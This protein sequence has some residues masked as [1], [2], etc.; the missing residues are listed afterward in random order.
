MDNKCLQCNKSFVPKRDTKGI[1]C[2]LPCYHKHMVGKSHGHKT[3][4]GR[5]PWNKGLKIPEMCGDNH[6]AWKGEKVSY[7]NL[8]K[9]VERILGKPHN[10]EECKNSSLRHRQYNW[11]NISGNYKRIIS[12]W[13]R[14]CMK[15][16]KAFDMNRAGSL[17]S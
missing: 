2:S 9:W 12:D 17:L 10:C 11:S 14:L 5:I 8:H 7:R 16:H 1:F 6:F 15:C 3:T 4:N 13:R